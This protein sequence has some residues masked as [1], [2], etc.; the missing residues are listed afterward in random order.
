[1]IAY[2]TQVRTIQKYDVRCMQNQIIHGRELMTHLVDY[3][4]TNQCSRRWSE[5]DSPEVCM[6]PKARRARKCRGVPDPII[7]DN[8]EEEAP[9]PTPEPTPESDDE[10]RWPFAKGMPV[11][12]LV[13]EV[14]ELKGIEVKPNRAD[15]PEKQR[16]LEEKDAARWR[17]TLKKAG[18]GR[19][20]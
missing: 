12:V 20:N 10:F 17:E 6:G 14:A 11:G 3:Y 1:M 7:E 15:D 5:E 18:R 2:D 9:E 8:D 13:D 4:P 19:K 16:I